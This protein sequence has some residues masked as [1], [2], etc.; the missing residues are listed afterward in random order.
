MLRSLAVTAGAILFAALLYGLIVT[1]LQPDR[2]PDAALRGWSPLA[3]TTVHQQSLTLG[4]KDG[5]TRTLQSVSAA[6]VLDWYNEDVA[7]GQTMTWCLADADPAAAAIGREVLNGLA[8]EFPPPFPSA[9]GIAWTETCDGAA[10]SL[11]PTAQVDCGIGANAL[12]CAAPD[13]GEWRDGI[14]HFRQGRMSYNGEYR[15]GLIEPGLDD[16]GMRVVLAHEI[17]HLALTLDHNNCG[18]IRDAD[19]RAV[20]S[21]MT[22]IYLPSGPSCS[23]PGATGL[24]P[25][26]WPG[27]IERYGLTPAADLSADLWNQIFNHGFNIGFV[28]GRASR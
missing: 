13:G 17:Q 28:A 10:Y 8:A 21:V 15:D 1:I 25:A 2:T 19:G 6:P 5:E 18:V 24:T 12:G 3:V 7:A 16:N 26:D 22:P 27:A 23:E 20:P 9:P 11:G 14:Y 4:H